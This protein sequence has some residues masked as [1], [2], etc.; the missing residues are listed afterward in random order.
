M[1]IHIFLLASFFLFI[2]P[3]VLLSTLGGTKCKSLLLG[4]SVSVV[5][6]LS[7]LVTPIIF[8]ICCFLLFFVLIRRKI[9]MIPFTTDTRPSLAPGIGFDLST[10]YGTAVIRHHNGSFINV[11]KVELD[12]DYKEMMQRLSLDSSKHPSPPYKSIK[13]CLSDEPR[14]ILRAIRKRLGFPASNDVGL[15]SELIYY[16]RTRTEARLGQSIDHVVVSF[17]HNVALY[18]EDINDAIEYAG[19]KPLTGSSFYQQPCELAVAFAGSGLGLCEHYNDA[20]KCREEE[21]WLPREQVL[22]ISYTEKALEISLSTIE[23]AYQPYTPKH[24]HFINWDVGE[25]SLADYSRADAYW[26]V[27]RRKILE[28]S[29]RD[30]VKKPITQV[31]LLGEKALGETFQRILLAALHEFQDELPMIHRADPLYLAAKGAAEFAKRAQ[32]QAAYPRKPRL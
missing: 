13:E 17:S 29:Y 25:G 32:E 22:A 7:R 8:V 28:L 14:Q 6:T 16:L 12:S 18:E 5:G 21:K 1:A 3:F 9:F 26:V 19:L 20:E 2:V 27:V 31:L 10:S 4:T 15:L 24:S 23:N 30:Y 11:A